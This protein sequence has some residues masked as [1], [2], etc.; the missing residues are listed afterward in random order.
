[1][2]RCTVKALVSVGVVLVVSSSASAMK[3][4]ENQKRWEKPCENGPDAAVPGFLFNMGPTG[5]RGIL[6]DRSFVVKYIFS[7][8]PAAGRL[9]LNDEVIGANGKRFATHTWGGGGQGIEG[10]IQDL[11]LAIEDSEGDDGVLELMV[12]RGG[13]TK[14]VEIQLEKLGRFADTFPVNCRKTDILKAR[15]YKSLMNHPG[16]VNSQGRCVE[17]LALL[18]ADDPKVSAAGKRMALAWN[19]PYNKDTWSWHLGFQGITLAEYYLLTGDKSVLGT[20]KST[21]DLLR[22]AQWRGPNIRRWPADT[23]KGQTQEQVDRHQALYDGG[24]GHGPYTLIVRRAGGPGKIGGG[25]YGPMQRPTYLAIMAWQLGKQCGVE[26]PYEGVEAG[27]QFVEYGTNMAGLTAYGGEFTMNNGPVNWER[28][29][30]STR[31]GC[32]HK[33]GM[34]YLLYRLSPERP[35]AEAKMKLHLSNID[36]AYKDMADGHACPLMGLVWGWAGVYA[37]EDKALK[38]KIID[39]H[40][41][42]INMARCH[43]SDSYVVLP[44]RN[45]ADESYYRDNIRNHTT[46]SIAFLYSYSSPKCRVQGMGTSSIVNPLAEI[47][48]GGFRITHCRKE[49]NELTNNTPF[50]RVLKALDRAAKKTDERGTEAKA[51][52]ERLRQWIAKYTEAVIEK[53]AERPAKSVMEFDEYLKLVKGL[54]EEDAVSARKKELKRDRNVAALVAHYKSYDKIVEYKRKSGKSRQ[55]KSAEAK[56]VKRLEDY[57][58]K[59]LDE[60]LRAEAKLLL[61][62]VKGVTTFSGGDSRPRIEIDAPATGG[63]SGGATPKKKTSKGGSLKAD[64]ETIASHDAVLVQQ[65]RLALAEGKRPEFY[66]ASVQSKA[67]VLGVERENLDVET[68][69]PPM[70]FKIAMN[71]L[72]LDAKRSLALGVLKE[73]IPEDHALVAFYAFASGDRKTGEDH[74]KEAGQAGDEVRKLFE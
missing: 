72:T 40:K 13:A 65:I 67:R 31:N 39:Y 41:A 62:K 18:S 38:K 32:S 60:A 66:F 10:P 51:F 59:D 63:P 50:L 4:A 49:A 19:K 21:M 8:S 37:S 5:A 56:L 46:A 36:A 69:R 43:G 57:L 52:A 48:R 53:S 28:W 54:D 23:S 22:L 45:Y 74:L 55:T 20:L 70:R 3:D 9:K 58:E 64:A 33:S 73:G 35:D 1:M 26:I 11:G 6:K 30:A 24:F 29:K 2:Y 25:G 44:G 15:A 16:G 17:T 68:I 27:F 71:R 7:R 47:L 12:K 42:W 14:K 61:D 34:A